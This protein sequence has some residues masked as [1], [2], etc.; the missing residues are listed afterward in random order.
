M[1]QLLTDMLA[2]I[3]SDPVIGLFVTAQVIVLHFILYFVREQVELTPTPPL[4]GR[5]GPAARK[6]C[7]I[8]GCLAIVVV[9]AGAAQSAAGI[10]IKAM[11]NRGDL[12]SS[13]N[14]GGVVLRTTGG[15]VVLFYFLGVC[16]RFMIERRKRQ[17]LEVENADLRAKL[18][19]DGA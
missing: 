7:Q 16:W 11:L 2:G 15:L 19:K 14:D 3:H 6:V 8:I 17:A 18:K 13:I 10:A 9:M 5:Y 1:R 4:M 12:G